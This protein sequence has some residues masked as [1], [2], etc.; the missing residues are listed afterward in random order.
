MSA[1]RHLPA[2]AALTL[3]C[4]CAAP[5]PE[6]KTPTATPRTLVFLKTGPRTEPLAKDESDRIFGGHF[7]N[8]NRLA[9][10]GHLLVAGP[11]GKVRSDAGLRGV[12]VLATGERAAAERL[13]SSDPGVAAGVFALEY[14]DLVT[15]APLPEFLTAELAA[16]DAAQAAGQPADPAARIRSYVLLRA[17]AG[18]AAETLLQNHPAVVLCGRFD[19]TGLLAV[20]D[21]ASVA[22]AEAL[23]GTFGG[24]LGTVVLD[25]WWASRGLADL[26]GRVGG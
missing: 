21:V 10:A 24:R 12:F 4:A 20:L 5:P 18:A 14:H 1:S 6:S 19:G 15:A 17:S 13:A 11:F 25:E 16:E 8:M 7:A 3:L 9:R 22:A 23:V 2:L 26:A